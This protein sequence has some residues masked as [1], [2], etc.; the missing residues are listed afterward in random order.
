M[1]VISQD[2]QQDQVKKTAVLRP[3]PVAR[4]TYAVSSNTLWVDASESTGDIVQYSWNLHWTPTGPDAVT[5]SP[6]AEFP[7]AFEGVPPQSGL[8]TLIVTGR[9]GQT[10]TRTSTVHFRNRNPFPSGAGA[11]PAK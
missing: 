7:I 8:V 2:G 5:L 9:D 6:T 4:F 3:A 10:G 1:T 11:A